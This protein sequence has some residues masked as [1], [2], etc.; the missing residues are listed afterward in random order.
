MP[1]ELWGAEAAAQWLT[2]VEAKAAVD[3]GSSV[4]RR[5][6]SQR[7]AAVAQW[8]RPLRQWLLTP[9]P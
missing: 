1:Q 2:G 9:A 7:Y 6:E 8:L 3:A 4:V 5:M